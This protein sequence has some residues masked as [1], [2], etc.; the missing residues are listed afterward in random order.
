MHYFRHNTWNPAQFPFGDTPT[1]PPAERALLAA[2]LQQFQLGE[3]SDGHGLLRRSLDQRVAELGDAMQWFIREEQRHATVLGNFLDQE[4]IPRLQVHWV[5][6]IFRWLR[7]LAGFELML[8]VLAS[9]EYIAVPFYTAIH[10]VTSSLLLKRICKRILAQHIEFQADNFAL[11]VQHRGELGCFV[12]AM[13]QLVALTVACLFVYPLYRKVF[14]A[15]SMSPLRFW[16]MA[17]DAH[18]PVMR[19]LSAGKKRSLLA[20]EQRS[21][22][23]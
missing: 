21:F 16:T 22:V 13:A 7:N 9:A 18:R 1:L 3:G 20:P 12:T 23:R 2:P 19:V 17:V 15:A 8:T 14:R 10:E 11:C 6:R 4:S 5:D